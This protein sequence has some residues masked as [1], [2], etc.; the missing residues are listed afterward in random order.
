VI[1][2]LAD[3]LG[4]QYPYRSIV[5]AGA[6]CDDDRLMSHANVFITGAV[7]A[8]EIGDV[9]APHH[10]GWLLTDFDKPVFGHPVI[11]TTRQASIPVAYR[12][13]S[14]GSAKTRKGDLAI[15]ADVDEP[16]LVDAII[17]WI[18]R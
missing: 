1:R 9:L 3:R 6:T 17:E 13:W 12:D 14:D 11:E 16:G 5:V 15:S 2:T 4:Q 7:A 10:P 8:D 18:G